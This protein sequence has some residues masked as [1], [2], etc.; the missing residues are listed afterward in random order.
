MPSESWSLYPYF[1]ISCTDT[2]VIVAAV[3]MGSPQMAAKMVHAP[4][5][6]IARPP[7]NCPTHLF[8]IKKASELSLVLSSE[9]AHEYKKR[10]GTIYIVRGY[11][12]WFVGKERKCRIH[13]LHQEH[14]HDTDQRHRKTDGHSQKYE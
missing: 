7:G 11:C 12:I 4:T 1:L 8:K 6:P 3:E 10:Y 13:A 9:V 5:V 14:S 2:V